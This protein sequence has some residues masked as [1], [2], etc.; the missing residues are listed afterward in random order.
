MPAQIIQ[1]NDTPFAPVTVDPVTLDIIENA[2]R[3]ARIEMDATLVRTAMSPGIREQ[4]DAFPL[5]A[6]HKGRMVVGQFGSY[7]GPFLDG[8]EGTVEEGDMI[9][10]RPLFGGRRDQPLQRLAGA[11][12]GVQ[13][14]APD[15]LHLDVRPS[16]RH[17]RHGARID[18]DPCHQHLSGRRAHS[19]GQD[20]EAGRLQ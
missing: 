4:G 7:I 13:G 1:A 12:A 18:A 16:E 17:R 20:L 8:Y 2:L 14:W 19:A 10:L 15:R 3:N 6:D 9:F 11:S 5:I